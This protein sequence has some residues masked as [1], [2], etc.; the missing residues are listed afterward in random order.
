MDQEEIASMKV[1]NMKLK[2]NIEIL[3][4]I[5]LTFCV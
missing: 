5:Q 3:K 1:E 4:Y 2:I